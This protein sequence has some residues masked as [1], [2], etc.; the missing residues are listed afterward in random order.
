M[1]F[2]FL[3]FLRPGWGATDKVDLYAK[4][5]INLGLFSHSSLLVVFLLYGALNGLYY[6]DTHVH[7]GGYLI[8][9]RFLLSHN[10]TPWIFR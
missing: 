7:L 4:K 9:L 1:T 8:F 5:S 6:D 10:T 2:F 3:S